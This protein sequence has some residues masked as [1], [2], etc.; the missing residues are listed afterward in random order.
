VL[1]TLTSQQALG[2]YLQQFLQ[3]LQPQ[4]QFQ[5]LQE[6]MNGLHSMTQFQLQDTMSLPTNAQFLQGLENLEYNSH[7]RLM[8]SLES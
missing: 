8:N 2:N 1:Q 3:A 5:R 6:T 7:A 4:Q